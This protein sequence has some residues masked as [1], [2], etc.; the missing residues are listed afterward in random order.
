MQVLPFRS[1]AKRMAF[2]LCAVCAI[3]IAAVFLTAKPQLWCARIPGLI[4][5]LTPAVIFT[6]RVQPKD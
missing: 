6:R 4:P 1:A 2:L 3:D 5:L